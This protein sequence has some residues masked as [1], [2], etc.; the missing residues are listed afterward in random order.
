MKLELYI[1]LDDSIGYNDI[2]MDF[3]KTVKASGLS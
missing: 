2:T 3:F 1:R